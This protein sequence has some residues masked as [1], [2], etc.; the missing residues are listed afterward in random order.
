MGKK[1]KSKYETHI[2]PNLDLIKSW[3]ES[4]KTIE[5]IAE[6]IGVANSTL[7]KHAEE[8]PAL[9]AVLRASKEKLVARLKKSLWEEALGYEYDEINEYVEGILDENGKLTNKKKVKRTT[10][11]RKARP[12]ATLLVFALCNFC[13][14]EFQ[15]VDKEATREFEQKIEEERAASRNYTDVAILNAYHAL[16]PHMAKKEEKKN[17]SKK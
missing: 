9:S 10:T 13:P 4:G 16:Y 7:R 11:K 17:D 12:V 6:K 15:R 1:I 3:R 8:N 5:Q 2:E 14:E